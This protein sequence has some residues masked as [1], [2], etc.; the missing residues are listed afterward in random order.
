MQISVSVLE[1]NY[2]SGK[3][4]YHAVVKECTTLIDIQE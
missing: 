4:Y 2:Y 1:V 3:Y